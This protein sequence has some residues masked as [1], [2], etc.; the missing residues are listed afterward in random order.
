M[1][2][3]TRQAK[4]LFDRTTARCNCGPH[5][6]SILYCN[7]IP[8]TH[9][10]ALPPIATLH[11]VSFAMHSRLSRPA[12][13]QQRDAAL[14]EEHP[15]TTRRCAILCKTTAMGV[16]ATLPLPWASPRGNSQSNYQRGDT[17]T[18]PVRLLAPW[19]VAHQPCYQRLAVAV[20]HGRTQASHSAAPVP[21]WSSVSR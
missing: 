21:W 2:G 18:V 7:P 11:N 10:N 8:T 9:E 6:R 16:P 17:T 1:H 15:S 12:T 20:D 13:K 4:R 14:C 5:H 19:W 3:A